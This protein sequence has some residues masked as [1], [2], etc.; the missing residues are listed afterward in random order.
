MYTDEFL[1]EH[2][3]VWIRTSYLMEDGSW[4]HETRDNSIPSYDLEYVN[5]MKHY[6]FT[7]Q[8]IDKHKGDQSCV[9]DVIIR[10]TEWV[11]HQTADRKIVKSLD[12][13][14]PREIGPEANT[15]KGGTIGFLFEINKGETY[16]Q[17]FDRMEKTYDF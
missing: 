10:E 8:H 7:F 12:I 4:D 5:K 6:H 16:Q 3:M 1:K 17:A 11:H 15:Y 9:A 14:F 2:P 13:S